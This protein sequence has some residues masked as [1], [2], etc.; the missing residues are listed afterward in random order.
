ME[1]GMNEEDELDEGFTTN[2]KYTRLLTPKAFA[3]YPLNGVFAQRKGHS[4]PFN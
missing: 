2:I 3:P 4:A 1:E